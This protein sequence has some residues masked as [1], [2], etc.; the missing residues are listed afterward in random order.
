MGQIIIVSH[1]KHKHPPIPPTKTPVAVGNQLIKLINQSQKGLRYLVPIAIFQ[2]K[3]AL[4]FLNPL[5]RTWVL[6]GHQNRTRHEYVQYVDDDGER[7]LAICF[8][9]E[10]VELFRHSEFHSFEITTNYNRRSGAK[11]V[12]VL[13]SWYSR[14][15][16]KALPLVRVIS[17]TASPEMYT[18]MYEKVFEICKSDFN[19]ELQ[20]KHLQ[21]TGLVGITIN[22][23]WKNLIGFGNYLSKFVDPEHHDWIWQVKR[24][25]RF[26]KVFFRLELESYCTSDRSEGSRYATMLS[27]LEAQSEAEYLK[28][29]NLLEDEPDLYDWA[30]HKGHGVI[31]SGL[32]QACSSISAED[33]D[34]FCG[35]TNTV[36][37]LHKSVYKWTERLGPYDFCINWG[38]NHDRKCLSTDQTYKDPGIRAHDGNRSLLIRNAGRNDGT[39]HQRSEASQ[40][41]FQPNPPNP[42]QDR[43]DTLGA[44]FQASSDMRWGSSQ[45]QSQG[46]KRTRTG[47]QTN[48]PT[49]QH[50]T[51]Q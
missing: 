22:Q 9:D 23:D 40:D 8:H 27:I 33:W 1:G 17:N 13:W 34:L 41:R 28:L 48:Q 7:F 35:H 24:C 11:D 14:V 39:R 15:T 32:N 12:E 31:R 37:M 2:K 5:S 29:V 4:A 47:S 16:Q 43:A 50:Q 10:Q 44:P 21:G 30:L 18:F 49:S 26:C 46:V 51:A 36:G 20:W 45:P 25:V 19:I 42:M 6:F 38:R 3:K